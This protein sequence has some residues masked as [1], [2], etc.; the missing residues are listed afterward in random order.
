[1]N[2]SKRDFMQV[3]AAASAAGMSLAGYTSQANFLL[4]CGL[5]DHLEPDAD[6][7]TRSR[8]NNVL[9]QL[10][11]PAEMGELF[12]VICMTRGIEEPLVGFSR[13][14]RSHAL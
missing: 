7:L 3:L 8:Q 11:S 9:N 1:M 12:K 13:G 14:D 6:A 10:T 5:L 2:L 4:N